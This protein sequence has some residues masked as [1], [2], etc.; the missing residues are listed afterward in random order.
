[1]KFD[2]IKLKR[3]LY[4]QVMFLSKYLFKEINLQNFDNLLAKGR[5][6]LFLLSY[7]GRLFNF[8]M[9]GIPCFFLWTHWCALSPD[10]TLGGFVFTIPV[11]LS[12][13]LSAR[14]RIKSYFR[15]SHGR[16][17]T[18]LAHYIL[19]FLRPNFLIDSKIDSGGLAFPGLNPI[20]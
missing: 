2:N 5:N 10:A 4:R 17:S 20:L 12:I 16:S 1:M 9:Y 14:H 11:L 15:I 19:T 13:C 6:V 3:L 8:M 7:T 18:Y